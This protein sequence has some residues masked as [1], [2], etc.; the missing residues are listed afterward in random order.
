MANSYDPKKV[1][2]IVNGVFIVGFMD[3]TFVNAE[4]N[5]DN[6]TPHIGAQGDVTYS[7]NANQT[8]T[9]TLTLKQDSTS[10]PFLQRQSKRKEDFPVQ[11]IDANDGN[12]KAGGSQA[13]I[14]KTPGREFGAE[15]A[16]VE[17]QIHVADYDSK[18]A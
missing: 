8:G 16:G 3:G 11:V 5:A 12:F 18:A 9:I 10:L 4:K 1:N 17:V 14:V 13:R 2:V 6:I 7:E 15:I